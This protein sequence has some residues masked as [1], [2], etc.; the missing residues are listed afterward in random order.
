[1]EEIGAM[2]GWAEAEAEAEWVDPGFT[3]LNK[4]TFSS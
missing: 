1:M 2:E 4:T 3:A